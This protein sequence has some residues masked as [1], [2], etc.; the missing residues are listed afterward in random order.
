ME[1]TSAHKT[2]RCANSSILERRLRYATPINYRSGHQWKPQHLKNTETCAV[3]VSLPETSCSCPRTFYVWLWMFDFAFVKP[4]VWVGGRV[5]FPWEKSG[6]LAVLVFFILAVARGASL[7]SNNEIKGPS[8]SAIR[9][10][11]PFA[12][13]IRISARLP[14]ALP[15]NKW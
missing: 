10:E 1:H 14:R 2:M 11:G 3:L 4:H 13:P 6:G 5:W 12:C 8:R 15:M 9:G 7:L